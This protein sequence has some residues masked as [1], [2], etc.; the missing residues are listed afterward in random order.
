MFDGR[1]RSVW[2]D[3]LDA[4]LMGWGGRLCQD[5]ADR[6]RPPRGWQIHD[7]RPVTD[8]APERMPEAS[9]T[10]LLAR[11]FRAARAS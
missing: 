2:L 11:A 8:L 6:L 4:N 7:R 1:E 9:E 10:P 5:H 3:E